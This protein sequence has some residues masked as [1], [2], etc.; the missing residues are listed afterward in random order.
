MRHALFA[1][2]T[3]AFLVTPAG[4]KESRRLNILWICADDHAAYV[5]GAY[6][7]KIVRTPHLDQLARQGLR[8]DRAFCNA[9]VCTA[10]RQSF[11]TGRY[12][13]SLGVT[14]LQSA[15][16]PDAPTLATMLKAA[17]YD[18]ASFGKMHFNSALKHGFDLRLDMPDHRKARP[19]PRRQAAAPRRRGAACV[20]AVPRSRKD[21]AQQR[22]PPLRGR[23]GRHVRHL[24]GREGRC[25]F[26]NETRQPLFPDGEL[27]RA[28]FSVSLSHRVP[29]QVSPGTLHRPEGVAAGRGSGSRG[30]SPADRAG[31]AGDFGRLLHFDGVHG[32]QRRPRAVGAGEV[33]P[34]RADAGD[35]HRRPRLHA[36][37]ARPI[38]EALQLRAGGARPCCCAGRARSRRTRARPRWSSLWTLPRPSWRR[39]A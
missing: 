10:S 14:Q 36:R 26:A 35:L 15:L 32:S 3:A 22:L 39:P 1:A 12:P 4:A 6:G 5:C 16:P 23:A 30:V 28:A 7:N 37:A 9:P 24:A 29:R 33:R 2:L 25:V 18:T 19:G 21:L 11:L 27:H 20:E 38:R 13:R 34:G 8:F 31:E 17:G